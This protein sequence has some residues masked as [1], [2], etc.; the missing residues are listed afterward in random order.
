MRFSLVRSFTH[1]YFEKVSSM[2][3]TILDHTLYFLAHS[4]LSICTRVGNRVPDPNRNPDRTRSERVRSGRVGHFMA[5]GIS[6]RV[7]AACRKLMK[8]EFLRLEKK[9]ISRI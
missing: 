5:S 7:L 6:R 8:P 4:N 2:S 3:D 9:G 1:A